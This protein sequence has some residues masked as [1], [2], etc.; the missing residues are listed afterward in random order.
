MSILIVIAFILIIIVAIAMISYYTNAW[1]PAKLNQVA[2]AEASSNYNIPSAW[3]TAKPVKGSTCQIYTFVSNGN[4]IPQPSISSLSV[5]NNQIQPIN[6][7]CIDDDQVFA[8][9]MFHVCKYGEFQDIPSTQF[10]GCPKVNGGYTKLNGYYE[11]FFNICGNPVST[12][13]TGTGQFSDITADTS[14]RCPGSIGLIMFNFQSSVKRGICLREPVYQTDGSNILMEPD[15]PLTVARLN[16]GTATGNYPDPALGCNIGETQNGFPSQL[17]R[18]TRHSYDG[19]SFKIDNS[20]NWVNIIH[21]PTGKYVAPYTLTSDKSKALLTSFIPTLPPILISGS[22]F[23]G[24]GCWWYMTPDLIMPNSYIRG[25]RPFPDPL[26][27]STVVGNILW[28]GKYWLDEK[29]KAK[30]QLVWVP[31][32]S[33][34]YNLS[35]NDNLWNFLTSKEEIVYSLAPFIRNGLDIDYSAMSLTPF[36]T[37]QLN[38]A[39]NI[40]PLT[41][42]NSLYYP[43]ESGLISYAIT[44]ANNVNSSCNGYNILFNGRLVPVPGNSGKY[45]IYPLDWNDACSKEYTDGLTTAYNALLTGVKERIMAEAASF[46]YIDLA[47]YPIIMSNVS[48]YYKNL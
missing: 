47:L 9:K 39:D 17:F 10:N 38:A 4:N 13:K 24:K 42:P 36:I 37:Y 22:S 32:P 45:M 29:R 6:G 18:V 46:Q 14:V 5:S 3:T 25:V 2:I 44:N 20:G 48:S 43:T 1:K 26:L 35:G 19:K 40:L 33:I 12:R 30:P 34:L 21:R 27:P 15:A 16:G 23:D 28:D 11:E 31:D 7:T 8:Q 41:D